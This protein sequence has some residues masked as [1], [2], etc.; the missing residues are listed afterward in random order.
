LQLLSNNADVCPSRVDIG[1]LA[2]EYQ[3]EKAN[4]KTVDDL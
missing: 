1:K 2:F 3:Q 4:F